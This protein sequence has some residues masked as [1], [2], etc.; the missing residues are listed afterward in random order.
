MRIVNIN[1]LL[2]ALLALP[3][4]ASA[5]QNAAPGGKN[6]QSKEGLSTSGPNVDL[7]KPKEN[8]SALDDLKTGLELPSAVL[9]ETDE[10]PDFVRELVRVQWRPVDAIDLWVIRP[11]TTKKVPV[12][13]YLYS[14]LDTSDRFRD[15][16]WAKRAAANG[17]AAVGFS[18]ALTDYRFRLRPMKEWF[19]SELPESLGTTVHDVQLILNYIADRGDMDMN[20]VGMFGMGSGGAIAILAASVDHRIKTL[21]LLDPWGDWP[22]WLKESPEV[23]QSERSKYLTPEFL[24]SVATLD[25]VDHLAAL[26]HR[27]VR[28]QQTLSEPATPKTAKQHLAAA[29]GPNQ[30]VQYENPKDLLKAWQVT[31]LSG[32]IKEQMLSKDSTTNSDDGQVALH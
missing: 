28:L 25:P 29:M 15:N 30:V 14:Y 13:L 23:P 11:K 7:P 3:A 1:L 27:N 5:Q 26:K 24:K 2:L 4:Q 21:D 10:Q 9:V 32:W 16:G 20:H 31:G 22:D 12:I 17:F 8:W 19:V 6:V 18:A